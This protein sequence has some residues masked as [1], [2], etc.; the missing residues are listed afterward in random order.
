MINYLQG[1][2]ENHTIMEAIILEVFIRLSYWK[3]DTNHSQWRVFSVEDVLMAT[4]FSWYKTETIF[5]VLVD[6][7][8]RIFFETCNCLGNLS[9]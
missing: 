7:F 1:V 8:Q 3:M 5:N 6:I 2:D 4:P 9:L